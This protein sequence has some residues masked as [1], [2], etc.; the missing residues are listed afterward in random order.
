LRLLRIT[1]AAFGVLLDASVAEAASFTATGRIY[2]YDYLNSVGGTTADFSS[3]NRKKVPCSGVRVKIWDYDDDWDDLCG[4]GFTNSGGYYSIPSSCS[5]PEVL[6]VG[7]GRPEVYVEIWASSSRGFK[8]SRHDT[9]DWDEW[10]GLGL[11]YYLDVV[12]DSVFGSDLFDDDLWE[13]LTWN[14]IIKWSTGQIAHPGGGTVT[15][16]NRSIGDSDEGFTKSFGMDVH[17][18]ASNADMV[19]E[20]AT[21]YSLMSHTWIVNHPDIGS[22]TTL[23]DVILMKLSEMQADRAKELGNVAHELG[24]VL[25]NQLHSGK[26]HW[27]GDSGGYAID[28]EPCAPYSAHYSYY[29]G[30]ADFFRGLV[31]KYRSSSYALAKGCADPGLTRIRNN[32]AFLNTIYW[33]DY[34]EW[35]YAGTCR[36]TNVFNVMALNAQLTKGGSWVKRNVSSAREVAN[37]AKDLNHKGLGSNAYLSSTSCYKTGGYCSTYTWLHLLDYMIY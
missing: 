19:I 6:G 3:A 16:V 11:E 32:Y 31:N 25:H 28:H 5:D 36:P 13:I 22:P 14:E 4:E 2:C 18:L 27:I 10:I 30:Y 23:Y 15:D 35:P 29:E 9:P 33:G 1:I 26:D 34:I 17:R 12:A 24:H 21:G 20:M 37:L 7:D 8:V